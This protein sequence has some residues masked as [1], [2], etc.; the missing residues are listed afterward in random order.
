M[1]NVRLGEDAHALAMQFYELQVVLA[2]KRLR[3]TKQTLSNHAAALL[4]SSSAPGAWKKTYRVHCAKSLRERMVIE[5]DALRDSAIND[6]EKL[7]H[8]NI[9]FFVKKYRQSIYT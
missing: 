1:N 2:P 5:V 8:Q 4:I 9:F 3:N 7:K 6:P